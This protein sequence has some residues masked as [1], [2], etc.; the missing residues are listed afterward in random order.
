MI[1]R[2]VKFNL[3]YTSRIREGSQL[4]SVLRPNRLYNPQNSRET[5]V[6]AFVLAWPHY[7]TLKLGAPKYAAKVLYL[8]IFLST[9]SCFRLVTIITFQRAPV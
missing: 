2:T 7:G 1:L 4:E 6:Y 5:I 9:C 8:M 3:R